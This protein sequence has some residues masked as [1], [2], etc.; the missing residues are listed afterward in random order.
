MKLRLSL[1][2]EI[3]LFSLLEVYF[4]IIRCDN[5]N[6]VQYASIH[7]IL[8]LGVCGRILEGSEWFGTFNPGELEMAPAIHDSRIPRENLIQHPGGLYDVIK[9]RR[10]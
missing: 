7:R 6:F 5:N 1:A 3:Y 10:F 9:K 2:I 4:D 8:Q